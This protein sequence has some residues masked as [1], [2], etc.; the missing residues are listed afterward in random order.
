MSSVL[1]I[2]V[3]IEENSFENLKV[4]PARISAFDICNFTVSNCIV[5]LSATSKDGI[6]IVYNYN[7]LWETYL[8]GQSR[9]IVENVSHLYNQQKL[10][11][12]C[13]LRGLQD[14]IQEQFQ[15]P[16]SSHLIWIAN[17]LLLHI[18]PR[19]RGVHC[20]LRW[21][22]AYYNLKDTLLHTL[23]HDTFAHWNDLYIWVRKI[24]TKIY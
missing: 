9:L 15:S 4:F 22:V 2:C 1:F 6:L 10:H 3:L 24:A 12:R 5:S 18:L 8:C 19:T 23:S 11:L 20:D 13:V 17:R 14:R 7:S 21:E 16:V